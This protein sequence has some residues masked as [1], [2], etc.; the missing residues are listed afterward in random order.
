MGSQRVGHNLVTKQQKYWLKEKLLRYYH[1][2]WIS[3]KS[4]VWP[5]FN[6]L[7]GAQW[8]FNSA[9]ACAHLFTGNTVSWPQIRTTVSLQSEPVMWGAGP[10]AWGQREPLHPP[11]GTCYQV[12]SLI[13]HLAFKLAMRSWD[14]GCLNP[15]CYCSVTKLCPTLYDPMNCNTPGFPVLHH[16]LELAQTHVRWV[17]D[18]IQPSHPLSSP[19]PPAFNLSQHLGLF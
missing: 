5:N 12:S 3:H 11:T 16:L 6:I 10:R 13:L 14:T 9:L 7:E 1:P 8:V 18:V 4:P 2:V 15:C 17:C 19:S